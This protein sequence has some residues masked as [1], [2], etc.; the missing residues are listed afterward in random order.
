MNDAIEIFYYIFF[1]V[2][3][4]LFNSIQIAEGVSVGWVL[5][6]VLVFG[7]LIRSIL[8]L[9]TG[10]KGANTSSKGDD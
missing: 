7:I 1:K 10:A 4:L 8:N 5:V 9:P 3:N 6:T 2:Y